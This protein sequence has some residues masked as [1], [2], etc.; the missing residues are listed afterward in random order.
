MLITKSGMY[1]GIRVHYTTEKEE[2]ENKRK[3][4][5]KQIKEAKTFLK[6]NP[7]AS[8]EAELVIRNAMKKLKE[9]GGN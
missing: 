7:D 9:L 5:L 8:V 4:Y 2:L 6:Y 3:P 1:E